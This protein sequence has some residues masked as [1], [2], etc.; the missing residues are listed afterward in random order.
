[1]EKLTSD[2]HVLEPHSA[3][4][5]RPWA[6]GRRH[7]ELGRESIADIAGLSQKNFALSHE[8]TIQRLIYHLSTDQNSHLLGQSILKLTAV[9]CGIFACH[10]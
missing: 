1:M 3:T 2:D 6:A 7:A 10:W 4:S 5:E 8:L 9:M